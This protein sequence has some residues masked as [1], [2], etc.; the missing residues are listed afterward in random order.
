M[1]SSKFILLVSGKLSMEFL[2]NMDKKISINKNLFVMSG[3]GLL[4]ISFYR[5][6]DKEAM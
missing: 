5:S 1:V 2:I 3:K 4:V 6:M